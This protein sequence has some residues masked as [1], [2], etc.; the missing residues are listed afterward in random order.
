MTARRNGEGCHAAFMPSAHCTA[1]L[2]CDA[3]S[4]CGLAPLLC[5]LCPPYSL[6][7]SL[8]CHEHTETKFHPPPLHCCLAVHLLL[9][10]FTL[11]CRLTELPCCLAT[12]SCCLAMLPLPTALPCCLAVRPLP[13]MRM[14]KLDF[15]WPSHCCL[16]VHLLPTALPRYIAPRP[17]PAPPSRCPSVSLLCC[18]HCI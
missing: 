17:L 15:I 3:A 18:A 13:A 12:P 4:P 9:A 2:H 11:P 7:A 5:A 14:L 16:T 6:A 1:S 8:H 10:Q